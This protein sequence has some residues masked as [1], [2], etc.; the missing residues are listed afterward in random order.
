MTS[1]IF[2]ICNYL[3][4]DLCIQTHSKMTK[5]FLKIPKRDWSELADTLKS[6]AHFERLAIIHLICNCGAHQLEVKDI[7]LAL[8]LEQPTTSRHLTIMK[9]GRLLKR[10]VKK[11]KTFYGFNTQNDTALFLKEMLT[12]I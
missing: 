3:Q 8:H 1:V 2:K 7:Y 5:K 11:G 4:F 6:V 12:E 10:E 9:K